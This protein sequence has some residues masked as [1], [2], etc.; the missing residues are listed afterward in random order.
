LNH[1]F[2]ILDCVLTLNLN[3]YC[4]TNPILQKNVYP[5]SL[6]VDKGE[7]GVI[8]VL[9]LDVVITKGLVFFQNVA[10]KNELLILWEN[11]FI[12]LNLNF[13]IT[14]DVLKVNLHS[15]PLACLCLH[16]ASH[17]FLLV[18]SEFEVG[19]LLYVHWLII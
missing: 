10:A 8:D 11:V 1:R 13:Y 2:Q 16:T 5:R 4:P 19:F 6:A 7:C 12:F 18:V 3:D 15:Y 9:I 14:N 17:Y